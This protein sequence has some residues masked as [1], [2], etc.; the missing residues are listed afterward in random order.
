[1]GNY[2]GGGPPFPSPPL[3]RAS[4]SHNKT[5]SANYGVDKC[6]FSKLNRATKK[7]TASR[8][9]GRLVSIKLDELSEFKAACL[10]HVRILCPSRQLSSSLLCL[11]PCLFNIRMAEDEECV[12]GIHFGLKKEPE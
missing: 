8:F 3:R 11:V 5:Q 9:K 12:G 6:C 10:P 7:A 2:R 1:M 4:S